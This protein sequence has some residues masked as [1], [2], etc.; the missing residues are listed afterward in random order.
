M[1]CSHDAGHTEGKVLPLATHTFAA[2]VYPPLPGAQGFTEHVCSFSVPAHTYRDNYTNYVAPGPAPEPEPEPITGVLGAVDDD[3]L[4]ENALVFNKAWEIME[5][6][7]EL[8]ILGGRKYFRVTAYADADGN[9]S[10]RY[11]VLN[12]VA[13]QALTDANVNEVQ[14]DLSGA[15]VRFRPDIFDRKGIQSTMAEAGLT[16]ETVE[17]AFMIDLVYEDGKASY[18]YALFIKIGTKL[19]DVTE[20]ATGLSIIKK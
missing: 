12:P 6:T 11:L 18:Q 14:F 3:L 19:V 9:Y 17:F 20:Y 4:M 16:N 2:T 5:S 13:L 10:L 15:S 8:E 1:I 7:P